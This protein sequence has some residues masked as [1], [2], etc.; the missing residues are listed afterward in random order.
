LRTR[1]SHVGFCRLLRTRLSGW[2]TQAKSKILGGNDRDRR[3]D[4]RMA[5]FFGMNINLMG[6][7]SSFSDGVMVFIYFVIA[8]SIFAA[9]WY[10]SSFKHQAIIR[11]MTGQ[12]EIVLKDKF[13]EIKDKNGVKRFQ[14]LRRR[15]KPVAPEKEAIDI[16][17]K[18]KMFVELRAFPDGTIKWLSSRGSSSPMVEGFA[19]LNSEDA[20][21]LAHEIRESIAYKPK[22]LNEIVLQLAPYL[23]IL[24]ILVIFMI[25]FGEVVAPTAG[26]ADKL[27]TASDT[28]AKACGIVNANAAPTTTSGVIPP[29]IPGVPN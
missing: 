26:L 15:I 12:Q 14:F 2:K 27:A 19:Q 10:I 8:A 28:L 29:I 20:T 11:L 3:N 17:K 22:K 6:A 21:M 5:D 18:G 4:L 13:R 7:A 16:T 24:M 1:K 9:W 25:F 23:V